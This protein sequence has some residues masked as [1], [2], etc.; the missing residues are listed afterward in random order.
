VDCG[1]DSGSACRER[2]MVG[3]CVTGQTRAND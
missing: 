2:R 1:E 3:Q